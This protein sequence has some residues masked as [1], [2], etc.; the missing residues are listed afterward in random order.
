MY[1]GRIQNRNQR[2]RS[3]LAGR[4]PSVGRLRE[5]RL[6]PPQPDGIAMPLVDG[7]REEGQFGQ[8]EVR[9]MGCLGDCFVGGI[10]WWVI[11]LVLHFGFLQIL[12]D[13]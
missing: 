8:M 3:T 10:A 2:T 11:F 4:M 5:V 6:E 13:K 12:T 9:Q 7:A 1:S